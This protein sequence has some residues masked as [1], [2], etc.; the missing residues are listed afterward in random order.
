MTHLKK[1]T[2]FVISICLILSFPASAAELY[3]PEIEKKVLENGAT[4]LVKHVPDSPLVTIQA[5]VLSGLSNEGVYA[6]TGISH[7]L[8]HL[9]FKGTKEK[10][11]ETIRREIKSM[12][13]TVNGSTGLDSAEYHIT[14]PNE[15]YKEA[16]DLL[17]EV[18]M[19]PVFTDEEME[20][21]KN[22]I[23]KEIKLNNDDPTSRIMRLLF[24]Q[25]YSENVYKYPIIGY[26]ETFR[27]LS[28]EDVT[29]YHS[30][31]YTP[32]RMVIGITGGVDPVLAMGAAEEKMAGYDRGRPAQ[33][34]VMPEPPQIDMKKAEFAADI[35]LGYLT[36]AFHTTSVHSPDLYATD[37]LAILLGG[38][39]DS[40]LYTRI[41]KEKEL[42]YAVSCVNYTPRHPGLFIVTGVGEP[43]NIGKAT[44]EIFSV[45]SELVRGGVKPQE[46]ERAKNMVV[47]DYMR[48]HEK[49]ESVNSSMTSSELLVGDPA[50][51]G[52]YV[53][54][55]QDVGKDEIAA[56]A[57]KYLMVRNSTAVTL[58]PEAFI[59]EAEV[60][61]KAGEKG[62]P[63]ELKS[64]VLD[65]GLRI[66]AK[67]RGELPLVTVTL[68][69]PGGLRAE[70]LDNNG[71]SN[72][73]SLAMLKGTKKR[74][75]NQIVPE[76]ERIGGKI[77]SFSGMNSMGLS[78][79]VMADDFERGM[80]IFEDVVKDA[81]FPGEEIEKLRKK[82]AAAI[83]EQDKDIFEKGMR[84]LMIDLYGSHPYSMRML[85]E[86]RSVGLIAREDIVSFYGDH[87]TPDAS[88]ITVVGNI[89][90]Q[91][92]MD[93]VSRRFSKWKGQSKP[94]EPK[95]VDPLEKTRKED[96]YMYKEQS[97][98]L[99]GFPGVELTDKRK[100][101]LNVISA[102]LSGSDGLLF[103]MARE[104][105][106]LAYASGA[107]SV[108]Q[109]D[110][111][112]FL[113]YVATTEDKLAKANETV[114][115]V[116]D[117]IKR[118]EVPDGDIEASKNRLISQ[119]AQSLESNSSISMNMTLDE[120]YG[121]GAENYEKYPSGIRAVTKDDILK[122][123]R[124]IFGKDHVVIEVHS[125]R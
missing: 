95:P 1:L 44:E 117:R 72:L 122:C 37:V 107:V 104:E 93:S 88:V 16:L 48:S 108:P 46:V 76:I 89:D 119:H 85:G 87:V 83:K 52:K 101:T 13:G 10:N 42:L 63:E 74:R 38:G 28:R 114:S 19:S 111:G 99:L 113:I 30:S 17:V 54:N 11:S 80:D 120:L 110:P 60:K 12:G 78:I 69:A 31:A 67:K 100:Y 112:Y 109:I 5:R 90:A 21:E 22:V 123:A 75:E 7:Y 105:E 106:G 47:A 79:S 34:V 26:E 59:E 29:V 2:P 24:A 51:Y 125:A 94:I 57:E 96:T 8:E 18:V 27:K 3:A 71:I 6:G 92:V 115:G 61:E 118:G 82:T 81:S 41:V 20:K 62:E 68:A 91:K 25:A 86:T 43:G 73:T 4:V 39:D 58:L 35:G 66:F 23:L 98:L 50:F 45:I 121:L 102:L 36:L 124:D 15:N 116:L 32:D 14:V 55:I 33:A 9:L 53:A 97:L 40:R 103:H 84:H 64:A 49:I 70:T 56:M 65:N 77:N